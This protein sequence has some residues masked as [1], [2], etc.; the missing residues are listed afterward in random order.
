MALVNSMLQESLCLLYVKLAFQM[1]KH[2]M[3][4]DAV[5]GNRIASARSIAQHSTPIALVC[6]V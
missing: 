2:G 6:V 4:S 1:E 3:P 5:T